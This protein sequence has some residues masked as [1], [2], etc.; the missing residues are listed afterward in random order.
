MGNKWYSPELQ[1]AEGGLGCLG[2]PSLGLVHLGTFSSHSRT[3]Q[4]PVLTGGGDI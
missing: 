1:V 4:T 3:Q 2:S